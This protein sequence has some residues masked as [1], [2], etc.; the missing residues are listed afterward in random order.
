MHTCVPQAAKY[1]AYVAVS[2]IIG[3]ITLPWSR[4]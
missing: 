1:F 2:A 4:R 3:R